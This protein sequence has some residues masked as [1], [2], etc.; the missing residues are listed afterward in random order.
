[1]PKVQR[2]DL[3]RPLLAHL[4]EQALA[5]RLSVDDLI[6]LRRWL[7]DAPEG[8]NGSWFKRFSTFTLCGDGALP[9]TFFVGRQAALGTGSQVKVVYRSSR[10]Q[11][12]CA[13]LQR[14]ELG[15]AQ[16]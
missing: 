15:E 13:I 2:S 1:M 12:Q 3:P 16:F 14:N 6:A 10:P 9:K 11:R 7:E 8:P 5:R 4:Y